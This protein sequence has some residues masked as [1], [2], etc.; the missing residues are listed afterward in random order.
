MRRARLQRVAVLTALV[1]LVVLIPGL[2]VER[3]LRERELARI[4][5]SLEERAE[6]VHELTC[7]MPLPRRPPSSSTPSPTVREQ[8]RERASR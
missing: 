1:L 7:G 6:L 2:L 5:G 4:V 3:S 8:P